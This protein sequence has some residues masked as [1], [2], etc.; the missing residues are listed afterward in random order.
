MMILDAMILT[1]MGSESL[2]FWR[3]RQAG[4]GRREDRA[5][6]LVI[7]IGMTIAVSLAVRMSAV[8]RLPGPAVGWS[9]VGAVL[10]AGGI[11][12]R[13]RAVR[14]LGLYFRTRVTLL[15]DHQLIGDGPYRRVRHPS[16]T[17][18]LLS[19]LAL[20]VALGSAVSVAAMVIIPAA[21]FAYRIRVEEAAL[22]AHFGD[23]WTVYRAHRT[24]LIPGVW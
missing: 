17:G 5:S 13:Q 19:C 15:D 20:G 1:W 24:A 18:G 11:F 2:I 4:K 22:A 7:F 14:W 23:Q 16:Y 9:L 21:A 6:R 3:D 8:A 12:L 10:M